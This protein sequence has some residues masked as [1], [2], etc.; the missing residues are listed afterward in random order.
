MSSPP[1]DGG[2]LGNDANSS[3]NKSNGTNSNGPAGPVTAG[4]NGA[5]SGNIRSTNV[6]LFSSCRFCVSPAAAEECP[7][8]AGQIEAHGGRI[9]NYLTD[10][11]THVVVL[12]HDRDSDLILEATD[13]YEKPVITVC[14]VDNNLHLSEPIDNSVVN[15]QANRTKA[16]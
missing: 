12:D 3:L 15:L 5:S 16:Y 8:L 11:S 6:T 4:A 9:D 1:D 7:A 10:M 14:N 13:L 2:G